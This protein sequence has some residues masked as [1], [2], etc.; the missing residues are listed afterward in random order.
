MFL[1][2][3]LFFVLFWAIVQ[4]CYRRQCHAVASL[5]QTVTVVCESLLVN[6]LAKIQAAIAQQNELT[7]LL[8]KYFY[9]GQL[10]VKELQI[11]QQAFT[12]VNEGLQFRH[13]LRMLFIGRS[14]LVMFCSLGGNFLLGQLLVV[15]QYPLWV[16]AASITT[17]VVGYL[18]L[19]KTLP[20]SWFWRRCQLSE[21]ASNWLNALFDPAYPFI[22][23]LQEMHQ[24]QL[25]LGIDLNQERLQFLQ[26]WYRQRQQQEQQAIRRHQDLFPLVELLVF[27][28]LL[29][30][31]LL[32]VI[33][34]FI[35]PLTSAS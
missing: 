27:A 22:K 23:Q 5:T 30:L 11:L 9:L 1:F 6:D 34:Q 12:A 32:P 18:L 33:E 4:A 7:E 28:I 26:S 10:R 15:N 14:A 2:S 13:H 21:T 25:T 31:Y 17:V 20:T 8:G 24:R 19:D 3:G 35:K 29:I 16:I